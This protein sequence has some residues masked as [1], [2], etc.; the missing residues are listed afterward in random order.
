MEPLFDRRKYT[1]IS[2]YKEKRGLQKPAHFNDDKLNKYIDGLRWEISLLYEMYRDVHSKKLMT[3]RSTLGMF[4]IILAGIFAVFTLSQKGTD[5]RQIL[6]PPFGIGLVAI[7]A[8]IGI[9]NLAAIRYIAAFKSTNIAIRRQIHCLRQALDSTTFYLIEGV[10]PYSRKKAVPP[11][12]EVNDLKINDAFNDKSTNYW[13]IFG[14][15]RKLPIDNLGIRR[16]MQTYL[17]SADKSSMFIL[18]FLSEI[19][20]SLP[21]LYYF[22]GSNRGWL[23]VLPPDEAYST[24]AWIIACLSAVFSMVGV[25]VL[26]DSHRRIN[27]AVETCI[28]DHD[29]SAE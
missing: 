21:L 20:I 4:S 5:F 6:H 18:F 28:Y 23:P 24:M 29:S 15:H 19:L 12:G 10:F 22:H 14:N 7:L 11:N 17:E 9:A 13:K 8:G 16:H 27:K 2:E 25:W 3:I 26:Y 1:D